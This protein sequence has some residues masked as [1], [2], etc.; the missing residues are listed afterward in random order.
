MSRRLVSG[1]GGSGYGQSSGDGIGRADFSGD[2]GPATKGELNGP[3]GLALDQAGHP[4]IA[5]FNNA[6][7][8]VVQDGIIRTIAGG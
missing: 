8:R 1:A 2:S 3:V 6:R 4:Y 5:E 7:V